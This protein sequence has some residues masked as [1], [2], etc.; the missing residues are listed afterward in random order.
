MASAVR[1]ELIDTTWRLA[2]EL[3]D[4]ERADG[5][6]VHVKQ[7]VLLLCRRSDGTVERYA[8]RFLVRLS[9]LS[10]GGYFVAV[11][12]ADR[13]PVRVD[14]NVQSP[15]LTSLVDE[16]AVPPSDAGAITWRETPRRLR[17]GTFFDPDEYRFELQAY[18]HE[19]EPFINVAQR[20]D[21]FGRDHYDLGHRDLVD[22]ADYRRS[23]DYHHW[24]WVWWKRYGGVGAVRGNWDPRTH[25]WEHPGVE[26]RFHRSLASYPLVGGE[27][28]ETRRRQKSDGKEYEYPFAECAQLEPPF[29]VDLEQC[30]VAC[31]F[32]HGGSVGTRFRFRRQLDV[33]V[34]FDPPPGTALG[35]RRLRHLFLEGC[36]TMAYVAEPNKC[37]LF[38]AWALSGFIGGIRTICGTDGEHTSLDRSGWR[39]YGRY[40]KGDSISDAWTLAQVDERPGNNAVT[41]AFA[42][43]RA[44]ALTT[45][46]ESRFSTKRAGAAWCAV[47]VWTDPEQK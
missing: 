37:T 14:T 17:V 29:Y 25:G 47:S 43:T 9:D 6:P 28:R 44:E 31:V 1:S 40:N 12:S 23:T 45:L 10:G 39:F 32:T 22:A 36:S 42:A 20:T 27:P 26:V 35:Q 18:S 33:W 24:C 16:L 5:T 2:G 7:E 38:D 11:F 41:A 4:V 15:R 30:D 46:L 34:K 21:P 8:G 19:G 13:A 3:A